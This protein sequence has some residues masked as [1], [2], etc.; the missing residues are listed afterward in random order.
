MFRRLNKL[1]IAVIATTSIFSAMCVYILKKME[2][3][4]FICEYMS[5]S[6]IDIKQDII[7]KIKTISNCIEEKPGVITTNILIKK[8]NS[9]D[10]YIDL[11]TVNDIAYDRPVLS[12]SETTKLD[13]FV[14]KLYENKNIV[15]KLNIHHALLKC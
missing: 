2:K 5:D 6:L 7:E 9:G 1:H 15:E 8:Y 13:N 14:K 12:F 10:D 11:Y 4:N 3:I